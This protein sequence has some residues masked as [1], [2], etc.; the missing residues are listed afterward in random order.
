MTLI[1]YRSVKTVI[2][3]VQNS[4][5]VGEERRDCFLFKGIPFAHLEGRFTYPKKKELPDFLSCLS[6]PP[7]SIQEE[8]EESSI[9]KKEFYQNVDLN[10][11]E[12]CLYLN[13]WMPKK[14]GKYPVVLFFHGGA[15]VQGYSYEVEFSGEALAKSGVIVV[16]AQY[17]LGLLGYLVLENEEGNYGLLDQALAYSWLKEN[18]SYFNGDETRISLM[19]Q[20]A[21]A[22]SILS[23]LA[24]ERFNPYTVT[25]LS[26]GGING[27][28]APMEMR[29]EEAEKITIEFL[30]D[31]GL[32][33]ET[34]LRLNTKE[35][36]SLQSDYIKYARGK[37][38]DISF[39]LSPVYNTSFLK[40][41]FL[42]AIERGC[43]DSF[44]LL[45]GTVKYDLSSEGIMLK[46][47]EE[48][49]KRRRGESFV[50]YFSHLLP[51]NNTMPFHSSDLWYVFST[52]DRSWRSFKDEDYHLS[53]N[54]T[55]SLK[56]FLSNGKPDWDKYPYIKE[57]S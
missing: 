2:Q 45:C 21:G 5:V 46:A 11:N 55:S 51:P 52:L 18:I 40:Y 48:F 49:I 15:Y 36:L 8:C 20:S 26:F 27:P 35:I 28:I 57:L 29:R 19:G 39:P 31:K 47:T 24:T 38:E 44:P 54:L 41:S 14:E 33:K 9:Y 13:I 25:L 53:Y 1:Y 3:K 56:A 7:A 37:R 22:L 17:R 6:Y 42:E 16:T 4:F 30:K 32:S 34:L 43:Y 50:Y 10:I 12:E 23:L